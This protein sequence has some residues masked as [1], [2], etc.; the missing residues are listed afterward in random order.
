MRSDFRPGESG[1]RN[2][3]DFERMIL[4][5]QTRADGGR[6]SAEFALPKRIT[7]HN[8]R[9]RA[10]AQVVVGTEQPP[11]SGRNSERGKNSPVTPST[12]TRRASAPFPI[13]RLV[14]PLF[15][16]NA[17]KRLLALADPLVKRIAEIVP[18]LED[19]EVHAGNLDLG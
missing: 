3:N 4:H 11:G 13:R 12:D 6:V 16:A 19:A 14:Y 10:A 8:C 1:R 5:Y 2:T 18:M 9:R 15:Q 7:Q 17:R